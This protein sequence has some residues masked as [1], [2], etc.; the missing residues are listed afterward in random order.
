M[1]IAIFFIGHLRTWNVCKNNVLE[2]LID[3]THSFDIFVETYNNI[4]RF[5]YSVRGECN[6]NKI[7]NEEQIREHF[8]DFNV[9]NL[10]VENQIEM[11]ADSSQ[12][13]KIQ[14]AFDT[15]LRFEEKIGKYDLVVK[16]RPDLFFE[17]KINYDS[18]EN[19]EDDKLILGMKTTTHINDTFALG[20]S[21][22]MKKYFNRFRITSNSCPYKSIDSLAVKEK[23]ILEQKIDHYI[24]RLPLN[25]DSKHK[26]VK[27]RPGEEIPLDI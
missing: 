5:D 18:F 19:I 9:V 7:E 26:Y 2:N 20:K 15:L 24:I 17:E 16:T 22:T 23:I 13:I 14:K 1:K 8:S 6:Q 25:S 21:D 3:K 4:F 12:A 27:T 11:S 10:S